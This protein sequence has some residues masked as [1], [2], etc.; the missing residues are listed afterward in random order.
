MIHDIITST[1][2]LRRIHLE[3]NKHHYWKPAPQEEM[4]LGDRL[5]EK[6]KRK[7][8]WDSLLNPEIPDDFENNYQEW[9]ENNVWDYYD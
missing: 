4:S 2:D 8:V 9:L 5:I 7:D 6:Y 3:Y 1:E